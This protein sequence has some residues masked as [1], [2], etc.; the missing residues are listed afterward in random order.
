MGNEFEEKQMSGCFPT[1]IN[2]EEKWNIIS[3]VITRLQDQN[4]FLKREIGSMS[5][6]FHEKEG[7]LRAKMQAFE[8]KLEFLNA[9]CH[10]IK[11][12]I[13][14]SLERPEVDLPTYVKQLEAAN[15][16]LRSNLDDCERRCANQAV[17]IRDL[18]QENDNLKIALSGFV[19]NYEG[20]SNAAKE[21]EESKSNKR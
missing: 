6:T 14:E 10:D 19:G 16:C 1:D 13:D 7:N 2:Q 4:T 11:K 3:S 18:L 15:E 12:V 8:A 21:R 17:S 9:L 5:Q 20:K